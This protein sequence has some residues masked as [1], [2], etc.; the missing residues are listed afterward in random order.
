MDGINVGRAC[1][2]QVCVCV[3]ARGSDKRHRH[4]QRLHYPAGMVASW[5]CAAHWLQE[6]G[7][8]APEERGVQVW[9]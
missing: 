2:F 5:A 1:V 7:D 3:C 8:S 4:Q 9:V 6:A